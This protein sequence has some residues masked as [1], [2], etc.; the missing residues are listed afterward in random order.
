MHF[1]IIIYV[2][3]SRGFWCFYMFVHFIKSGKPHDAYANLKVDYLFLKS[4]EYVCAYLKFY[5]R[6]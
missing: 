3:S 1:E 5:A 6:P 2:E 4:A